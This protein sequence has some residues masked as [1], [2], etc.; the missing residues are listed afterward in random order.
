MKVILL[1]DVTNVGKQQQVIEVKSGYA[2]NYLFAN[3]LAVVAIEENMKILSDQIAAQKALE[4]QI[5]AEAVE[6]K[7]KMQDQAIT[8]RAKSGPDGK[9]YGA[10]TSKDIAE[11]V[12]QSVGIEIDKRK[13]QTDAIKTTGTYSVKI[14]LHPEVDTTI[15]VTV[16][17]E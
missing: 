16:E 17:N 11:A 14:K 13:I 12:H 1:K 8:L 3:G 2:N 6:V 7:N 5:K 15:S 10:V 4:A 9:L